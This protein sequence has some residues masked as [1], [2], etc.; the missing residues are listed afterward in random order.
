MP[1]RNYTSTSYTYGFNGKENDKETVGT[2]EGTRN[3]FQ[4]F[5]IK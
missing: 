2:G 1:G 5:K 3:R 4:C